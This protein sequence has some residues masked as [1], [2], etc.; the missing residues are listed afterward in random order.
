MLADSNVPVFS[1][2][3]QDL[4][5]KRVIALLKLSLEANS[6]GLHPNFKHAVASEKLIEAE[7]FT[8]IFFEDIPVLNEVYQTDFTLNYVSVSP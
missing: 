4:I 2:E 7:L 3:L 6:S 1:A 8:R 5:Q